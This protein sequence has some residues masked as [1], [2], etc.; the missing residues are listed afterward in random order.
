M[1]AVVGAGE[2]RGR[3]LGDGDDLA[4]LTMGAGSGL[5]ASDESALTIPISLAP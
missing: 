5:R 3:A 2:E 4:V 1:R